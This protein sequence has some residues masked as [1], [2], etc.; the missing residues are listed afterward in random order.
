MGRDDAV[1]SAQERTI[2][3]IRRKPSAALSSAKTSGRLDEGLHCTV[4]S[5]QLK[6]KMDM[7]NALG[8]DESA[9]TPGFFVRAGLIGCVAIGIK[10]TAAREGIPLE[11][12]D[13][14]VEMDFDDGAL[15]GLGDNS[16]APLETRLTIVLKSPAPWAAVEEMA[17]R[18]LA[19]DP[20]YLA[21][22]DAQCVKFA[23]VAKQA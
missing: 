16:A 21:I 3:I 18:A 20:Y 2:S 15:F 8:G 11:S 22:R 12:V 14:D 23:L 5:G 17:Q 7:P 6:V 13:V 1:R 4:S 10:M 9:P 19:A